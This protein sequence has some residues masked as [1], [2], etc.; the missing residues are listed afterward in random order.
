MPAPRSALRQ[1]RL[2]PFAARAELEFARGGEEFRSERHYALS[3]TA[4]ESWPSSPA[5]TESAV[6]PRASASKLSSSRWRSTSGASSFTSAG[7]T[8]SAP[9]Q[10]R[11]P[12][13]GEQQ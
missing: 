10:Q 3:L 4:P 11:A 8:W 1:R 12:L 9:L 5:S 6:S 13:G 7:T 2:E